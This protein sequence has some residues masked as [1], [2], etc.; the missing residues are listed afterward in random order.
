MAIAAAARPWSLCRT[1]S[2]ASAKQAFGI[3]RLDRRAMLGGRIGLG[4]ERLV[5]RDVIG[6]DDQAR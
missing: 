3:G 5:S 4:L 2:S 1:A 6:G